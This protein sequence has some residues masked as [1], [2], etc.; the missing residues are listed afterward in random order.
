MK[1]T[2]F[3]V[4][5]ALTAS[6][7]FT[8]VA[9]DT[10]L[11]QQIHVVDTLVDELDG[12]GAGTGFSLREAIAESQTG[13]LIVFDEALA[14]GVIVL[15][16]DQLEI[17]TSLTIDGDVNGDGS[18]DITLD[19]QNNTHMIDYTGAPDTHLR[20]QH[21]NF[22]NGFAEVGSAIF[23]ESGWLELAR[24]GVFDNEAL[25][26]GTIQ[27]N[28]TTL[29]IMSCV[30][31]RN[32][33]GSGAITV[34]DPVQPIVVPIV[35]D[36][37]VFEDNYGVSNGGAV[38][39]AGYGRQDQGLRVSNSVFRHNTAEFGGAMFTAHIGYS[40]DRCLFVENGLPNAISTTSAKF[41]GAIVQFGGGATIRFSRFERN[42]STDSGG[43]LFN[44]TSGEGHYADMQH[45]TFVANDADYGGAVQLASNL[46]GEVQFAHCTLLNNTAAF[47]AS[48][49]ADGH[50]SNIGRLVID[51]TVVG[52]T[53]LPHEPPA[54]HLTSSFDGG[55][56]LFTELSVSRLPNT[57]NIVGGFYNDATDPTDDRPASNSDSRDAGDAG[58]VAGQDGVAFV[59]LDGNQRVAGPGID[60]GAYELDATG[61]AG[62]TVTSVTRL[63]ADPTT[64]NCVRFQVTFSAP[65]D[66]AS[67]EDFVAVPSCEL[68]NVIVKEVNAAAA[69]TLTVTV[70]TGTGDGTLRLDVRDDD[71]IVDAVTR[72]PLGGFGDGNGDFTEGEIYSVRAGEAP[73]LPDLAGDLDHDQ[74]ID[75]DDYNQFLAT[76]GKG[77]GD[78]DYNPDADFDG[79]D[80]VGMTDFGIWY[81]H[82]L[83]FASS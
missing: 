1:R 83:A 54:P 41:G 81:S 42:A 6:M 15:T 43:A 76:Y 45:V 27:G 78:A 74:D 49:Q 65:I 39:V 8:A 35:I 52:D 59:D 47:G 28:V 71:S 79:D 32:V 13:D 64:D 31:E 19:G 55:H 40:I 30:F 25:T 67:T 18:A 26:G 58:L 73:C 75:M 12:P 23:H 37:C 44:A 38:F 4:L 80:F 21:I 10:C 9:A 11:P 51:H 5:T 22:R 36:N 48:I 46:D 70:T 68:E 69:D 63:D 60:I 24:C 82:Y 2:M 50:G 3:V 57:P 14:G 17:T 20:I 61:V 33:G 77:L 53:G 7:T 62:P 72:V 56:N 29:R 34:I 16:L 66:G